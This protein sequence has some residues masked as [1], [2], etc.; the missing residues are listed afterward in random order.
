VPLVPGSGTFAA[1]LYRF[2]GIGNAPSTGPHGEA[3]GRQ[4]ETISNSGFVYSGG[5][6]STS[7]SCVAPAMSQIA[8]TSKGN[9]VVDTNIQIDYSTVGCDCAGGG[10]DVAY[11]VA[12][13]SQTSPLGNFVRVGSTGFFVNCTDATVS[14]YPDDTTP[15]MQVTIASGVI[16]AVKDKRKPLSYVH[17]GVFDVRDPLY[18]GVADATETGGGTDNTAAFRAAIAAAQVHNGCIYFDGWMRVADQIT[19]TLD[20]Y[21]EGFCIQGSKWNRASESFPYTNYDSRIWSTISDTTKAVFRFE[22]TVFASGGSFTPVVLRNFGIQAASTVRGLNRGIKAYGIPVRV[23]NVGINY[24]NIGLDIEEANGPTLIGF[25]ARKNKANNLKLTNV[26]EITVVDAII[27]EASTQHHGGSTPY[28]G[29]ALLLSNVDFSKFLRLHV[30]SSPVGIQVDSSDDTIIEEAY[31]ESNTNGAGTTP[32]VEIDRMVG[33][34]VESGSTVLYTANTTNVDL[35]S[36]IH[37]SLNQMTDTGVNTLALANTPIAFN[38]S[39]DGFFIHQP[40]FNKH[41]MINNGGTGTRTLSF[42]STPAGLAPARSYL[43][44]NIAGSAGATGNFIYPTTLG[45]HSIKTGVQ[46][47]FD[48]WYYTA[49]TPDASLRVEF[50]G[51]DS[52]GVAVATAYSSTVQLTSTSWT[53][54]K[55]RVQVPNSGGLDTLNSV[56]LVFDTADPG[57]LFIGSI[58]SGIRPEPAGFSA[59]DAVFAFSADVIDVTPAAFVN[60]GPPDYLLFVTPRENKVVWAEVVSGHWELKTTS[61]T[62]TTVN[63]LAIPQRARGY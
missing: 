36:H 55:F 20:T 3:A 1:D 42:V 12:S 26:F 13:G 9:R 54:A 30:S 39:P 47:Y 14:S 56:R 40:L 5:L 29:T 35:L 7:G 10:S 17:S 41:Y 32:V 16:T 58:Y 59:Q 19:I 2:L 11:V 21:Q 25:T 52:A 15:L 53:S 38:F 62:L 34:R 23:D 33:G 61:T 49:T 31:F 43:N 37:P 44:I 48:I 6:H 24:F 8:Y 45:S 51:V 18:G 63:V 50:N 22:Q 4:I 57:D 60:V 27:P 46:L 28:T